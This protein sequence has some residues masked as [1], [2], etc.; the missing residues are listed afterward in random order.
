MSNAHNE[1]LMVEMAED[2]ISIPSPTGAEGELAQ[3]LGQRFA[4]LEMDV[5]LQ[6]VEEGRHNVLARIR[7]SGDGPTIMLLAHLDTSTTPDDSGDLPFGYQ[8][9][10]TMISR[11]LFG[12][13]ISNM[14]CA[15]AAFY[16][17]IRMMREVDISP[18]G[19]ILVAGVVGEIEKAPIDQWQGKAYRGGGSGARYMVNH[20]VTADFCLNGEPTGLRLQ[21]GNAGY[22]FARIHI[23]GSIQATFSR[24]A[25]I[26]PIPKAHALAGRLREWE[27][28]YQKR[29]SHPFMKPL[30]SVGAIHGGLPYKP[31]L[32][33]GYCT[34]YVHLTTI[35]QQDIREVQR[36]LE[37]VIADAQRDDPDLNATVS[38]YLVS[39]GHELD[40]SHPG[41]LAVERAHE[42]VTGQAVTRP[43]PERYSISSDNSPLAEFGIPGI[44]YGAGGINRAGDYTVYEPGI[45]EVVSI[46]NLNIC[47]RVYANAIVDLME[48]WD[49]TAEMPKPIV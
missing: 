14:K 13:G 20:G 29:N 47:S 36:D 15:F 25:A 22:I 23:K 18:P 30:L 9:T 26:D 38:F 39:N 49:S 12:L 16:S 19:E 4:E 7:G 41:A 24:E 43:N 3:Y 32:T 17:A 45:G 10:P 34:L 33:A 2:V 6:E 5:D 31:S 48:T 11:W 27:P 37:E 8:T 42:A 40:S 46:D 21:V 35:P 28:V 44:T 1:D